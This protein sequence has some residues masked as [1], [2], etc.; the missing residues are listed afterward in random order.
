MAIVPLRKV[1]LIGVADE[2]E[3]WIEPLQSL[4]VMHI[5]MWRETSHTQDPT[6][7]LPDKAQ[8]ASRYLQECQQKIKPWFLE[9]S[10]DVGYII[11]EVLENKAKRRHLLDLRDDYHQ[12]IQMR[13][14]WGDFHF[15]DVADLGGHYFWFYVIPQSQLNKLDT[16]P[17]P[18]EVV[19]KKQGHC[20]VIVLCPHEPTKIEVPFKRVRSGYKSL[21]RLYNELDQVERDLDAAQLERV[22]LTRWLNALSHH[23]N[24]LIDRA[25]LGRVAGQFADAD[26]LSC[27]KGWVPEPLLK[28]VQAFAAERGLV[29]VAEEI[30]VTDNDV[31]RSEPSAAQCSAESEPPTLLET[32]PLISGAKQVVQFFQT[33]RL[34]EPGIRL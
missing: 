5:E 19:N 20:Y 15:P 6:I 23:L 29:C 27:L 16:C 25:E 22:S 1:T 2:R 14:E 8:E 17:H 28:E 13:K 24:M 26:N 30:T 18:W 34:I 10:D 21:T 11:E 33:P 12:F 7:G 32:H 3:T 9:N 31:E 4:G